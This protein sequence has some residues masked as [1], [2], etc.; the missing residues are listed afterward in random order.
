MTSVEKSKQ[1][2][3]RYSD[4]SFPAYRF[5]PGKG[6][7]PTRDPE[8]HSFGVKEK[9][10]E[11]FDPDSWASCSQ[12]LYG[13]DLFNHDYWWE[14][15]EAWEAVWRAAG[16]RS[17]TGLF[18][19]GLIQI[20][21]ARLKLHQGFGDAAKR[22]ARDGLA[23]ISLVEGNYLGINVADFRAEV[24]SHFFHI[25]PSPLFIRLDL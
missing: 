5:V 10:L 13:V 9:E 14:A 19:Q 2:F 16:R 25:P 1:N 7:H 23:K 12:Y 8:G 18:T 20:S 15:H 3:P 4:R 22:L 24:Q 17:I 6:P 21:V 11:I